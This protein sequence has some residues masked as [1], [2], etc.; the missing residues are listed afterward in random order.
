MCNR[1]AELELENAALRT[2]RDILLAQREGTR[3]WLGALVNGTS[4]DPAHAQPDEVQIL[5]DRLVLR[6]P[7]QKIQAIKELRMQVQVHGLK[8]FDQTIGLK[9]AKDYMDAAYAR[10]K[11]KQAERAQA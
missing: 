2:E 9:E 10:A 8:E 5:A 1:C 11:G 6:Y 4:I 7:E 3:V